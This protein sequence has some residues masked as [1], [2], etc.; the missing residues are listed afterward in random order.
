MS[1]APFSALHDLDPEFS[2]FSRKP[3]V[4]K[5]ARE[6]VG[7]RNPVL[8]QSMYIFKQPRI[9]GEGISAWPHASAMQQQTLTVLHRS[10]ASS[11]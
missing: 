3:E 2:R 1:D 9:G 11:G 6:L 10:L 7:F 8:I 4:E 5:V